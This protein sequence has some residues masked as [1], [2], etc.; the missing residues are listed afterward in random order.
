MTSDAATADLSEHPPLHCY[1]HPGRETWVRCG[2]CEQPIC[3]R[4]AMQGP[5]GLRCKTCGKPSRDPLGSLRPTQLAIAAAVS[6]GGGAIVGYVGSA[7]QIFGL[8]AAFFG[9]GL[10]AEALDRTVGI[11]RGRRILAIALP[12]IVAGGLAGVAFSVFGWWQQMMSFAG[13]E[14]PGVLLDAYLFSA[15]PFALLAVLLAAG[16]AAARLR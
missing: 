11:K 15:L 5:V 7:M 16:V 3:S 13:S 2:R 6:L 4:C 9:G 1:R 12:G 14:E 8:V 10:I